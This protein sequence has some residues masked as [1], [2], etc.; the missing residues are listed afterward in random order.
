[1]NDGYNNKVS[2]KVLS[3]LKKSKDDDHSLLGFFD[4]T[5]SFKRDAQVHLIKTIAKG[6][7]V[8]QPHHILALYLYTSNETIFHQVNKALLEWNKNGLYQPFI[9]TLYQ[10]VDLLPAYEGEV[11][12]AI[13]TNFDP[14]NHK[15]GNIVK[16]DSFSVC[17]TEYTSCVELIN[18]KKGVI[19][20][21]KSK[22]GKLVNKYSKTEVDQEVMFLPESTFV[23]SNHYQASIICL[24]QENIR[25]TTF[26]FNAKNIDAYMKKVA[27]NEATIVVELTEV[28]SKKQDKFKQKFIES[29]V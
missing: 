1:M 12:R 14:E 22:S 24:G 2:E 3:V 16:W 27:N 18:K 8:L 23:I 15:I 25:N 26:S 17:S 28:E 20:I 6:E 29:C 10:A 21:I 19:F 5:K 7:T 4:K 9:N 13:E 11:Y